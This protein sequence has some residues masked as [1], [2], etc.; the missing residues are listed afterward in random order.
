VH[1]YD[2]LSRAPRLVRTRVLAA[3]GPARGSP[4]AHPAG[5]ST[6]PA[7]RAGPPAHKPRPRPM[8]S[9]MISVVPPKIVCT[10]LSANARATGNSRMYP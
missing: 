10:R 6:T 1:S 7:T 4:A 5:A 3:H 9:F 2:S 8:I